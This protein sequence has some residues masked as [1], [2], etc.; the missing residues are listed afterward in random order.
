MASFALYG[1]TVSRGISIGRAHVIPRA[2]LDVHHYLVPQEKVEAEVK[3]LE[4]AIE[5][6]RNELESIWSSLPKDAPVELG[7]FLDVYALI[8]SDTVIIK[9]PLNII[10][11]RRYNAEW[12]FLT[13]IDELLKQFDE[14]ED[15]YLRERK[16][17][18][19]QVA[20]RVM[21]NLQGEVGTEF[22]V[23]PVL[24]EVPE[25]ER[26]DMI[27]VAYDIS[28]ADMLQFR[29]QTFSGFISEV[30]SKNSHAAIVARSIDV[31][32]VFGL[33]N[34]LMLIE[35][36]DW[37][38]IDAD[39]G[40]V[41]VNPTSLV[42]EQY[43]VRKIT[44]EKALKK[45]SKLKKTPTATH[46]GTPVTLM[47]NIEFPDDCRAALENGAGGIGLFRSEFLFMGKGGNMSRLPGEDEQFDA[48]KKAVVIMRGRPVTIR[49][50]DIG[51]DK[52]IGISDYSVLNP[53]L[54]KRA[55]R[56]CLA[57]PDFF[58][59]QLRAILRASA[60]GPVK[61]LIP[62]LVHAFEIDQTLAMIE[63]AKAQ[64]KAEKIRYDENIQVGAMLEVPAAIL[65]LPMFTSRLSFLSIGTNDLIQYSLAIDRVDPE[66]AHLYNPLHPAILA[67]LSMAIRTG[68]K[69]GLPVSICGELAGDPSMTRL[70]LGMGLREFSMHSTQLLAVKQEILQADLKQLT[71]KVKR[72]L[73]LDEPDAIEHEVQKI[74]E[75]P[76]AVI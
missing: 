34:A 48:Y 40:V 75:L 9:E 8:L 10:R 22:T 41:V 24:T 36:D 21:K 43:R 5:A 15:A 51:A 32:A 70:L 20:E 54:G 14:I 28:P 39:T 26:I 58:L 66:V 37:L 47:A 33:P 62:M 76:A 19:R 42:L 29:D 6:V 52:P 46:D 11:T 61:L 69:A 12:A 71:P 49:T 23:V 30:G 16:A 38:I 7:A 50:L 56:F 68:E 72:V 67:M 44:R 63:Q 17:D 2:A 57:E 13:Q 64:L 53:A 60:F 3:R 59:T 55:I 31:P 74:R 65:A 35:Q 1:T 45:L 4:T 25:D 73:N 27:V 18:I